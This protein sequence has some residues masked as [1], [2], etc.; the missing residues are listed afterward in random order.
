M[1]L[2]E[3]DFVP[4]EIDTDSCA[5]TV[6]FLGAEVSLQLPEKASASTD[7]VLVMRN[8]L[9]EW[10][11]RLG[12]TGVFT[13]QYLQQLAPEFKASSQDLMLW[14]I[15]LNVGDDGSKEAVLLCSLR[16]DWNLTGHV[17]DEFDESSDLEYHVDIAS[18]NRPAWGSLS[19]RIT[20]DFN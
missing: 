2:K 19:L 6:K 12:D 17:A 13:T 3:S 20:N 14:A 8:L 16:F 4:S 9:A 7:D 11:N 18:T 10:K 5:A 1:N 15:I